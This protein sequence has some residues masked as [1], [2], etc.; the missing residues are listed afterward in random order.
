MTYQ[1]Q[2]LQMLIFQVFLFRYNH[3]IFLFHL[4]ELLRRCQT[5]GNQIIVGLDSHFSFGSSRSLYALH[6]AV[7][8]ILMRV[9]QE[10]P[11][12]LCAGQSGT[13][14]HLLRGTGGFA[15][16]VANS[17]IQNIRRRA[18]GFRNLEYFK[19]V[20][21]LNCGGLNIRTVKLA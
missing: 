8:G 21:Y 4:L 16:C 3:K 10:L 20:I 6:T 2:I 15:G 18:R 17:I 9:S 7:C 12:L 1:E 14:C 11:P 5:G 13:I 19:L